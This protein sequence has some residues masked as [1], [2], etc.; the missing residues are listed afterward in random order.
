MQR[1]ST[2][3]ILTAF[4]LVSLIGCSTSGSS[5][6]PT[7]PDTQ[8]SMSN[9][10]TRSSGTY[11]TGMYNFYWNGSDFEIVQSR[12][13][14]MAVNILGFLEPP[15]LT[16]LSIANLTL[17]PDGLGNDVMDV[18]LVITHPLGL[19][20]FNVFDVWGIIITHGTDYGFLEHTEVYN[21]GVP[22]GLSPVGGNTLFMSGPNGLQ[23]LNPD[24]YTTLFNQFEYSGAPDLFH[25]KDGMLTPGNNFQAT[26]NPYKYFAS[27]ISTGKYPLLNAPSYRGVFYNGAERRRTYRLQYPAG[28]GWND[29]LPEFSYAVCAHWE[30]PINIPPN[31]LSDFPDYANAGCPVFLD[32]SSC[33]DPDSNYSAVTGLT[34]QGGSATV[35][36]KLHDWQVSF[37]SEEWDDVEVRIEAPELFSPTP[38]IHQGN[39]VFQAI[40]SNDKDAPVGSNYVILITA[41]SD[42]IID[43]DNWEPM[44]RS[45]KNFQVI[46]DVT[47][48]YENHDWSNP[49]YIDEDPPSPITYPYLQVSSPEIYCAYVR[50]GQGLYWTSYNGS[51]ITPTSLYSTAEKIEAPRLTFSSG[52]AHITWLQGLSPSRDI[53]YKSFLL[54]GPFPITSP[55]QIDDDGNNNAYRPA[56][57]SSGDTILWPNFIGATPQLLYSNYNAGW[58]SPTSFFPAPRNE[59]YDTEV[60]SVSGSSN[61]VH[62]VAR[63]Y[64]GQNDYLWY[65]DWTVGNT[66]N[67][68]IITPFETLHP[69]ICIDSGGT[70]WIAWEKGANIFF[71]SIP[72][73]QD[74]SSVQIVDGSSEYSSHQP[75]LVCEET[76][77]SVFW[78][79][80]REG[81]N[82]FRISGQFISPDPPDLTLNAFSSGVSGAP[83]NFYV[84]VEP[85]FGY[86]HAVWANSTGLLHSYL[87]P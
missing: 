74:P 59:G 45:E 85:T 34:T 68:V 53:W 16:G 87:V 49:Q 18:D 20:Q 81:S 23:M 58:S 69:D 72:E 25:Y 17:G 73:G 4:L 56:I 13:S 33:Q 43:Y 35:Q 52:T 1:I 62:V 63:R 39:G 2:F 78:V 21:A 65:S 75:Q 3:L 32:W 37:G 10:E 29:N 47:V 77:V 50:D 54:T 12:S 28:G 79:D 44:T 66:L 71:V 80:N 8:T 11:L 15:L 5:K 46:R 14:E 9:Q 83:Y 48:E 70:V 86:Y 36:C 27:S 61:N 42:S 22:F 6:N 51:W 82:D 26:L 7:I 84:A 41:Q 64:D 38:M 55:D 30:D 60:R 76:D 31:G 40:V 19:S 24:G 67:E 57:S